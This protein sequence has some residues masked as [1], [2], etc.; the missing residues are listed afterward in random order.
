M[1]ILT[2]TL[3]YKITAAGSLLTNSTQISISSNTS[4]N[5]SVVLT[6]SANLT[7]D[8]SHIH[9]QQ[10][11]WSGPG[12]TNYMT[13]GPSSSIIL[14]LGTQSS[15]IKCTAT[16][17]TSSISTTVNTTYTIEC[18]YVHMCMSYHFCLLNLSDIQT[19]IHHITIVSQL[20]S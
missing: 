10:I 3:S 6:C 2:V 1:G 15:E 17:G 4:N 8:D 19:S 11:V 12:I 9:N 16:L 14:L 5:V 18:K 20:V 13:T 7:S